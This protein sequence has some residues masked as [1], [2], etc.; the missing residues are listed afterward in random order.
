M[1][2]SKIYQEKWPT[3]KICYGWYNVSYNSPYT[4]GEMFKVIR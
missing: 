2:V 1:A 4:Q 3:N